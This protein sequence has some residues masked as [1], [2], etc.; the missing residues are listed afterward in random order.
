MKLFKRILR[1]NECLV[2]VRIEGEETEE[3]KLKLS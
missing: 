3:K 1:N 2:L